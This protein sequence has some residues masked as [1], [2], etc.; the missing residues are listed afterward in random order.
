[1]R[2]STDL[3]DVETFQVRHPAAAAPLLKKAA[4]LAPSLGAAQARGLTTRSAPC[5][6]RAWHVPASPSPP[7]A[8]FRSQLLQAQEP[9]GAYMARF[10]SPRGGGPGDDPALD[11]R[12]VQVGV[13]AARA[14]ARRRRGPLTGD[15]WGRVRSGLP[16]ALPGRQRRRRQ[17]RA[18]PSDP[19][20]TPAC[21][22]HGGAAHGAR[23]LPGRPHAGP[24]HQAHGHRARGNLPAGG[25]RQWA[26]GQ[27][28][29]PAAPALLLPASCIP[30]G[31][32]HRAPPCGL[33]ARPAR[34]AHP[35]PHPH[36]PNPQLWDAYAEKL[37]PP[38]DGQVRAPAWQPAPAGGA[39]PR[40]PAPGHH[41]LAAALAGIPFDLL[42]A[43]RPL[44]PPP[45]QKQDLYFEA[46][47]VWWARVT[48]RL[49][50]RR[51]ELAA[52]ALAAP[53]DAD[54]QAEAVEGM[55][56]AAVAWKTYKVAGA[57]IAHLSICSVVHV[58]ATAVGRP[59]A[60]GALG[61]RGS[62]RG[63]GTGFVDQHAG[64]S[65][66]QPRLGRPACPVFNARHPTPYPPPTK[67]A[68]YPHWATLTGVLEA[69]TRRRER[70]RAAA[71]AGGS[72][73]GGAPKPAE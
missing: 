18:H 28:Y 1:M 24:L 3:A 22:G 48:E 19:H 45:Q 36:P 41:A 70:L 12:L 61:G 9:L 2:G 4:A 17:T 40:E 62:A 31:A 56:A 20:S 27:G 68:P 43:P 55:E 64:G 7:Q 44:P 11:A 32:P 46:L 71:A 10:V 53:E 38:T 16:G 33:A 49:V 59:G 35:P 30:P 72:S 52:A 26:R 54:L 42:A 63:G 39:S 29:T 69:L 13:G 50:A 34:P 14:G 65:A 57:L 25:A 51:S 5:R 21:P 73:S 23:L 66:W 58:V 37:L 60:Q 15:A 6:D 67:T 47:H 8:T